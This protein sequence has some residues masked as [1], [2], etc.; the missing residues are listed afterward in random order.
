MK[1]D[2]SNTFEKH[3]QTEIGQSI[4]QMILID[5]V[6]AIGLWLDPAGQVL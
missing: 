2:Y 4:A 3:N 6:V 1:L 5:N